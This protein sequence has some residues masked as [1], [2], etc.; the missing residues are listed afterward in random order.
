MVI[1]ISD[2]DGLADRVK[3]QQQQLS[4]GNK[5]ECPCSVRLSRIAG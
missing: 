5:C 1:E 2:S 4:L 3:E